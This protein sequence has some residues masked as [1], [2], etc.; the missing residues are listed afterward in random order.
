M[1][2]V[3]A[4]ARTKTNCPPSNAGNGKALM[5]PKLTES[6]AANSNT[7]VKSLVATTLVPVL[8]N[9]MGP[10]TDCPGGRL[11]LMSRVEIKDTKPSKVCDKILLKYC[12]ANWNASTTLS[13]WSLI[14]SFKLGDK[15]T[16][17]DCS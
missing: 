3:S 2:P 4:S 9:P 12:H 10:E 11:L 15:K 17:I 8:I 5:T 14:T 6:A 16:S 1:R 13:L 7:V